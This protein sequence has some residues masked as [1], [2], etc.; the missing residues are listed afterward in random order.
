MQRQ[1]SPCVAAFL[2]D[3]TGRIVGEVRGD[4]LTRALYATD[5]S[6][7][8]IVPD[9][10]VLPRTVED[11]AATVRACGAHGLPLTARG[12]GTGLTGG[13][14]NR[15]VQLDCSR[16][17][18][19]VLKIDPDKRTATVEP[20]VVLDELNALVK[21]YGLQFAPDVATGNRATIGGMIGNNS[22]GARSIIY[23]RTVDHVLAVEVVL[24]DGSRCVWG[25]EAPRH[26]NPLAA[27][28][29]ETLAAVGRENADEIAARYPKVLRSNGGY[30]LDRLRMDSGR[31]NA[32]AVICG[33]EGT[34]GVVV[35]ATLNL[36]PLPK[37]KGLVVGHFED[38]AGALEATPAALAHGPAAVELV[39]RPILEAAQRSAGLAKRRGFISGD[40]E[41]ILIVEVYEEDE[42]RLGQRLRAVAADLKARSFGYAWP[43]LTEA[44]PQADV[45]AVRK[46][47]LGLAMS[48]PGDWQ[49][50]A[51][52]EDTA[53]D[54]SRLGD[55]VQRLRAIL[56]TEGIEQAGYYAH[57]SV[58]CLHIRP[59]LNLK[60]PAD[61]ERM[62]RIADRVSSLALEFGG[63]MTGE[64]GDGI[65]RSCWLEKMYGPRIVEAFARVKWAFD[66]NNL[67]NPGKI[68]S[69]LPMTENLRHEG[70][71]ERPP[72]AITRIAGGA[73]DAVG[74]DLTGETLLDFS[75]YGGISGL[76]EMCSG[77]GECRQRLAG[78]MCPSYWATG[79]EK[80]STRGRA[81]ALRMALSRGGLLRGLDDPAI[82]ET[83]DL[84]LSCKACKTECPTG[85][86]MAKLKAEWLWQRQ[87]RRGAPR[88][89]RLI[90]AMPALA[91]WG[92]RLA[93][94]SNW[95]GGWRLT[96]AILERFFGL[97][98]RVAPPRFARR[99]FR[100][101]FARRCRSSGTVREQGRRPQ[102]AYFVDTW[103]NCFTPE[104]GVAAVKVLEAMGCDV[105]VP[106]T[107]CCGRPAIS[108]GL[109]VQAKRLA[110]ANV[111]V[112]APLAEQGMPILGTEPSCILT[113]VDEY[114]QLV[115]SE[116]AWQ[117]A[118]AARTVESFVAE[119]LEQRPEALRLNGH[120]D[121]LIYHGHCYQK[122]L[123]GTEAAMRVLQ[124]L[125]GGQAREVDSGCC[126]MAGSFGHETGHYEIARAIGEVR[127]FPAIRERGEAQVA[128]S[129][130]SC[131]QQIAHHTGVKARHVV[132]Y[133][134]EALASPQGC[135]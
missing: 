54:P 44:K 20:G 61:V 130:F 97:D 7:Y 29:E 104:V 2:D 19:R 6:I 127:L 53:V 58:G 69:P 50:Q 99:R 23:G 57:A 88:R 89:S 27:R 42:D 59:V 28:C 68:V 113:L 124:T 103:T 65:V 37:Y 83:M 135:A 10:V 31:V 67:L 66:P 110:E 48:K 82:E 21:P 93:P 5:A 76:A 56:A 107:R 45:W 129:G 62:R 22:G 134:A 106:A 91:E 64:H 70:G 71:T 115:R 119:T 86:D 87:Q 101:W 34:L 96:R 94:V 112:L 81:N 114:P 32:E 85:V 122:A 98:R 43:V 73:T 118:K 79:E 132:E 109:L 18:N 17:L 8:Q 40:P 1:T 46:S 90:A 121:K 126:G 3:L 75:A 105:V 11:V 33:S 24:S 128:V 60:K 95:I 111:A 39:D 102:V 120:G 125:A 84:C 15:G 55:Y 80:D 16:F 9:A 14:V 123:V 41:A 117:V 100:S 63:A 26:D 49:P 30:G 72:H 13:A 4:R 25:P 12:A 108:K 36:L 38:V 74:T 131:R 78:T 47:G 52:I 77:V 51:F 116:A 133:L 92:C 35:G